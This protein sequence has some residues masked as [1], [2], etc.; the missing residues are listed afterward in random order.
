MNEP[1]EGEARNLV[2]VVN[3]VCRNKIER[4]HLNW[5]DLFAILESDPYYVTPETR[6]LHEELIKDLFL[7][8]IL[9]G[10]PYY[11][12]N[13][14][15]NLSPYGAP[16]VISRPR[17]PSATSSASQLISQQPPLTPL[18]TSINRSSAAQS[19]VATT[20]T[21]PPDSRL[22][23]NNDLQSS[24]VNAP[25]LHPLEGSKLIPKVS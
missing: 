17:T 11:R 18:A 21:V 14:T 19:S 20:L 4:H 2:W 23:Q 16:A 5:K 9:D 1:A 7:K 6:S 13:G 24:E 10:N 3:D 15:R 8:C 22:V 12:S 25:E